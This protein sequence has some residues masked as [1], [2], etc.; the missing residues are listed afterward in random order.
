ML[1]RSGR[2]CWKRFAAVLLSGLVAA[3]ALGIGMAQGALAAS[4]F[5]SG[6]SFQISADT[7]RG[8]GQSI[9][10]MVDV[11]RKGTLVPVMV[12][13]FRHA[14]ISGLCN[15]VEF[16]IPVLGVYT[17]VLTGGE[18]RQVEVTNLFIDAT[19]LS[20][21]QST[22]G[23]IDLGVAAGAVTKGPIR[24]G[25]RRSRFFHPDAFAVQSESVV[26]KDVRVTSVAV[27][28]STFNVPGLRLQLK[29]GR[30]H[31]F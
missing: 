3:A 31:C 30:H 8:R 17:L 13:G 9:Y 29:R 20:A 19:S 10:P 2:T 28:A 7:L 21:G 5:I 15:S 12:Q 23:N 4:F 25:D 6:Q 14:G 24:P 26:L 27:S 16:P 18:R 11:T 22:S 1:H